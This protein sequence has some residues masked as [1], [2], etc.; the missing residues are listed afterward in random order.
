MNEPTAVAPLAGGKT[1]RDVCAGVALGA[2]LALVAATFFLISPPPG[3]TYPGAIPWRAG[4]WLHRVV[5]AMSLGGRLVSVR[6][7][8]IKDFA[9][10]LAA[11]TGLLLAAVILARRGGGAAAPPRGPVR[12]AQVLLGLWVGLSLLSGLW[13]GDAELARGQAL[14]YAINVAWAVALAVA[15]PTR[16]V[17]PLLQGILLLSA[18]AGALC[19]WY[20]HERNPYHRPGFPLGNPATLAAALLPGVLIAL[21]TLGEALGRAGGR[22]R[23]GTNIAAVAAALSLVP[24]IWCLW[25]TYSRGALLGLGAGLVAF[26][27]SLVSARWRRVLAAALGI[28]LVVGG[29]WWFS[30]SHLDVTMARGATM[31]FR[32]YAWRY[33]AELWNADSWTRVAG[34]GAAAY[35][36]LAGAY[37]ARDRALD[38]AAFMGEIVE[39]AHNELFEILAEIGLVGGVT[40]VGGLIATIAAAVAALRAR[41][42][43]RSP[44]EQT[45]RGPQPADE[46]PWPLRSLLAAVVAILGDAAFGSALRLPGV[47]AIFFTLVGVLWAACQNGS[48]V[49]AGGS[50]ASAAADS[51]SSA[52]KPAAAARLAAFVVLAAAVGCGWLAARNWV[53]V[54]H[55]FAAQAAFGREDYEAALNE[56]AAAR[57]RLLDPVRVMAARR[58]EVQC[59]FG[60]ARLAV[61][62][63]HAA[64]DSRSDARAVGIARTTRAYEAAV[65][66]RSRVPAFEYTDVYAARAAEWLAHL[67]ADVDP[68]TARTWREQ[69]ERAWRWQR[70]RTPYDVE[71]LLALTR[72]PAALPD[73]VALLRDALRFGD[74]YGPW[75]ATLEQFAGVPGF[76][77]VLGDF[78]AAAGPITPQTDVDAIVAS[79]APEAYR[80]AAAVRGL[81]GDYE[82]AAALAGRAAES[83]GPLRPRF[84]A[85]QATALSEQAD[86]LL[87]SAAGGPEPAVALLRQA[88]ASLPVIQRQQ[89]DELARPLRIRLA[90]GLLVGEHVDEGLAALE[91]ALGETVAGPDKLA[92]FV[93]RLLRDA[94]DAG[95]PAE[96]IARARRALCPRFPTFCEPTTRG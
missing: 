76:D 1:R 87:R 55:E 39:H 66:L 28:A 88:L 56:A 11:A 59:L 20:F 74:P 79:M 31:R 19:V 80:L 42:G 61:Q 29:A 21:G 96:L 49:P 44:G 91:A 45:T 43:R 10:H 52:R 2:A 15:L 77:D 22:T 62:A 92:A 8:E 17:R 90:L 37:A 13:A 12:H 33:A 73:H 65:D 84:P 18:L 58:L 24:L 34:Q 53:G 36:R 23:R 67:T 69:A 51:D 32:L 14:L 68:S 48:P 30:T 3:E 26:G 38:P 25:L 85:L 64:P 57:R 86:Y 54:Q 40:W 46:S 47:P 7:V 94:G 16:L 71:T 60:A 72:Y 63:W 4:S 41:A 70:Q 6:G 75:R 27:A 5:E 93:Q 9:L 89:Y 35:P 82:R 81:R 50:P 95:V 78:L 83:Y